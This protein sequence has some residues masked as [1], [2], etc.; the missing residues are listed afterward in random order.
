[1]PKPV[2]PDCSCREQLDL[3]EE[4]LKYWCKVKVDLAAMYE[5]MEAEA[6]GSGGGDCKCQCQVSAVLRESSLESVNR[7]M[8]Q[9]IYTVRTS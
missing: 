2:L 4:R 1:M 8:Y 5:K 6:I 7:A 9:D 3:I